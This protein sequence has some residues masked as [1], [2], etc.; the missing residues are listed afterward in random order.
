MAVPGVGFDAASSGF[1]VVSS[2]EFMPVVLA[3]VASV[4]PAWREVS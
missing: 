1:H 4:S 2:V 3:I